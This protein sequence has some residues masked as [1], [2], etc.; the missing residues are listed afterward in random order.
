VG[1]RI[2]R[3]YLRNPREFDGW[4]NANAILGSILAMGM[5]AMA[6]A[7]LNSSGRPDGAKAIP[8]VTAST[9]PSVTA[10]K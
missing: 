1:K 3:D 2:R 5:L 10:S 7:G 8:S 6:F 9:L 4:L